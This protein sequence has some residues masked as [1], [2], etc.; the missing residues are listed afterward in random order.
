MGT[1]TRLVNRPVWSQYWGST[2]RQG[3]WLQATLRRKLRGSWRPQGSRRVQTGWG[4]EPSPPKSLPNLSTEVCMS[5]CFTKTKVTLEGKWLYDSGGRGPWSRTTASPYRPF[6]RSRKW[7]SFLKPF[8]DLCQKNVTSTRLACEGHPLG[9]CSPQHVQPLPLQGATLKRWRGACGPCQW[10]I[11]RQD[12]LS[13]RKPQKTHT[14]IHIHT[15]AF[16]KQKP[17]WVIHMFQK[18][19]LW[20]DFS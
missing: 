7:H 11:G 10:L 18:I 12:F 16:T 19:T 13:S 3:S 6:M 17:S 15:S 5:S 4:F 9:S 14:H 1:R 8:P 2:L 20:K